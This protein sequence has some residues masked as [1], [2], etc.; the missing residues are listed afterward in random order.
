MLTRLRG[1]PRAFSVSFF[2]MR[3]LCTPRLVPSS[4]LAEVRIYVLLL[5]FSVLAL[6]MTDH[7]AYRMVSHVVAFRGTFL[8]VAC[9]H[10]GAML[11]WPTSGWHVCACC[12]GA[13]CCFR[14][15]ACC[16]FRFASR[17][18]R[19]QFRIIRTVILS[20]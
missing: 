3:G 9:F 16:D 10:L 5:Q 12:D 1:E 18:T 2:L 17:M 14:C 11:L 13:R 20:L 7:P 4:L 8:M 6:L 15:Y 19:M